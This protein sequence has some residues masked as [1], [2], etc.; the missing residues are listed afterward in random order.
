MPASRQHRR[1]T[2]VVM[3][4]LALALCVPGEVLLAAGTAQASTWTASSARPFSAPKWYPLRNTAAVS[5]NHGNAGCGDYHPYWAL[6]LLGQKGDPVHAAGAGI[7]HVGARD[8][9]CKSASSPDSP[10]TWVWIDHGAGIVSRYHH[11]DT[12]KVAEGALVTP[13]TQIGTMGS[14]GDFAP[15]TTNYLH[16]EVRTGGVKG[17]RV[18]PGALWGCQGSKRISYPSAFS[19]A[20]DSWDDVPKVTRWT[21]QL[22]NSCLPTSTGTSTAPASVAVTRDNASARLT[23]TAPVVGTSTVTGYVISQE[24]WAPSLNRWHDPTYR[25][26]SSSQLASVVTGLDNGRRYRFRVLAKNGVGNSAWTRSV[27]VVPATVP[28]IPATDRGLS[29]SFD[30]VRLAW[31]KSTAQGTPVT[32]YT[33]AIRRQTA[34]GWTAWTYRT[35]PADTYSHKFTGLRQGT[36]YQVTVRANSDAGS[37]RYGVFR[38]A[39]TTRR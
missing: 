28:T 21:P 24:L 3:V 30:L 27:E 14:T 25:T 29:V 10:G 20:Y 17:T 11:L 35:V 8:P 26:V 13:A 7:L 23:W 9:G 33:V 18:D 38:T 16:F 36:T 12:I 37:S 15:C 34:S 32:S 19:S 1:P 39:T 4:L 2:V 31:W 22:D 5:C 6:D